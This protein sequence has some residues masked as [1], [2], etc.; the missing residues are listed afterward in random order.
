MKQV[1]IKQYPIGMVT[2]ENFEVVD[3]PIPVPADNQILV[4]NLYCSTDPYLRARMIPPRYNKSG[5]RFRSILANEQIQNETAGVV[6]ESNNA[7]YNIGDYVIHYGGWQEYSVVNSTEN[8]KIFE[9]TDDIDASCQKN[10]VIQGLVGRTAYYSLTKSSVCKPG[11][12][13]CVSGA[14]GGVGHLYVQ[15]AKILGASKVYGITSTQSKADSIAQLGAMP[16]IVPKDSNYQQIV[17]TVNDSITDSIDCYHE[18]VSNSYF[19]AA[20][21]KMS[22]GSTMVYCGVMALYNDTMPSPGP[23]LLPIIYQD[24]TIRGCYLSDFDEDSYQSFLAEHYNKLTALTTVYEGLESLPQQFVE[25]FTSPSN[26]MG[27]S[28]CKI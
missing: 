6:I 17:R 18:N 28:L 23:S 3:V 4:K 15:M 14:D 13:V 20:M 11:D 25:H 9:P 24:I 27:K 21:N 8:I 19:S 5:N 10:L 12:I 16:V 26:R 2:P 22:A 7:E 1:Q